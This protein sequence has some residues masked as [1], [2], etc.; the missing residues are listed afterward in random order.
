MTIAEL[1]RIAEVS[2][3]TVSRVLN[4]QRGVGSETRAR[5]QTIIQ[6][7]GYTPKAAARQ[8]ARKRSYTIGAAMPADFGTSGFYWSSMIAAL[9]GAVRRKGYVLTVHPVEDE[10][11]E[12]ELILSALSN[13]VDGLIL[14]GDIVNDAAVNRLKS[15]EFPMTVIGQS[16]AADVHS[17]SPDN[18][19]GGF[20]LGLQLIKRGARDI[21]F[22]AGPE[23]KKS[24]KQRVAGFTKAVEESENC[25]T[26][27]IHL[28]YSNSS[29]DRIKDAVEKGGFDGIAVSSGD[30]VLP[31]IRNL[32]KENTGCPAAFFDDDGILGLFEGM[33]SM[34][35][36]ICQ[37]I[38]AIANTAADLLEN[39]IN[40]PET[41]RK[42]IIIPVQIKETAK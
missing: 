3:G 22:I 5:I 26:R 18:Y 30:F 21:L 23:E 25:R 36:V 39:I 11:S 42:S 2:K 1:A 12:E 9:T 7:T 17:V 13:R 10:A 40:D 31:V 14:F 4:N 33:I 16:A 41:K 15:M 19:Q 37:D 8:L 35:T 6:E 28:E 34:G 29:F 24:I 38:P 27:I 32:G 20:E